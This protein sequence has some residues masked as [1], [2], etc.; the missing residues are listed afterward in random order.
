MYA[1]TM[2][3]D[4]LPAVLCVSLTSGTRILIRGL[5]EPM[6]S[7]SERAGS[8]LARWPLHSWSRADLLALAG[9]VTAI[10]IAVTPPLRRALI[11]GWRAVL[12]RAG[13]PHRKY[14]RWF[15]RQWGQYENPY[16]DD[17][18]NLDLS[19]TYVPLSFR[20]GRVGYEVLG[21]ATAV[22]AHRTMGN[23]V[24]EGAPGS[25]K[26]TL[27]KAYGVGVLQARR[28]VWQWGRR[29]VPF[30]IQ[31]RK[32]ARNLTGQN[33]VA[34]YIV[35]EILV[36]TIGMS[37]TQA[38][39]FF[40]YVL[41]R[42][43]VLVMLDG[44][45]EVTTDRYPV[46]LEAVRRFNNDH[47]PSRPTF[48]ARIIV[49]CRRQNFLRLRDEWV[50]VI[51]SRVC[52][53]A[54]LRNSDIFNYLNKLRPKFR[55]TNGPESFIQAVRVSG[56]L[57]LHRV[58]LILA[59][60]VGLYA[61]KDYF[62]IPSSIARLYKL[63][64]EEMLDR[65][66]FKRDPGG[67]ALVFQVGDKYRLLR[68]FALYAASGTDGFN[69]FSKT[70]LLDFSRSLAPNLDAVRDPDALVNEV[71]LRSG[72]LS[73]ITDTGH[74]VFAHRSIQEYLVAEELQSMSDSDDLLLG[75]ANDPEWRQVIQF[76]ASGRE[77]RSVSNFL[78]R[79][80]QLNSELAA[81]CLASARVSTDTA[82][83]VLESL[84]PIDGVRLAALAAATLSP[85]IAVQTMAIDSLRQ[86]VSNSALSSLAINGD[87]DS[88]L[89]LLNSLAGTNAAEIAALVPKVIE[90]IPDNPRLV[91]PLWRCLAAPGIER[92][93]ACLG[94]VRRLLDLMVDPEALDELARQE[95]Y[96]H[97][98]LTADI[99]RR[100]Y[101]FKEG[102][103]PSHNLITLLAWAEYLD[104]APRRS[105]RYFAAKEAGRLLRVEDDRRRTII[106]TP[107]RTARIISSA[108]ISAAFAGSVAAVS[109]FSGQITRPFGPWTVFIVAAAA[110][111][112]LILWTMLLYQLLK[113]L[114]NRPAR[115]ILDIEL[116]SKRS[117][118]IA[119]A[120]AD[121]VPE[122]LGGILLFAIFPLS[123][124]VAPLPL[125]A[126]SPGIFFATAAA[127][128]LL[129]LIS[130]MQAF[131]HGQHL[132]L[133]RPNPYIDI[134]DDIRCRHWVQM[135][136]PG[137]PSPGEAA[138]F[139]LHE[140]ARDD[141]DPFE[142]AL[143]G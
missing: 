31:L 122:L 132:Y 118:S 105:N 84:L 129:Y 113:G 109:V 59:M 96:T 54:P 48:Q 139:A 58:P 131:D 49:T 61:R 77:Q 47:D 91:E 67:G 79:L 90:R 73:D 114:K 62:E 50:P 103:D 11:R 38:N 138:M 133:Y 9:I 123:F 130:F 124:G 126:H 82:T 13:F 95:P 34:D 83:V 81:Y 14:A 100:A 20:S 125:L 66:R 36:S 35:D 128:E 142:T 111:G 44:L 32:L 104:V 12:M 69:E 15:I 10:V 41:E 21:I 1:L 57:D 39:Q 37:T 85:R 53:L 18:E 137:D 64:I 26:S 24:I 17:T 98:F 102:L 141:P 65:H 89:P 99:R 143:A 4:N 115:R 56:T 25:G 101:P 51:A 110:Y 80:S 40:R 46:V 29:T 72:L 55:L 33:G 116:T 8:I 22:L 68:E 92:Q 76:Y 127:G 108:V 19:N 71:V 16:L 117:G 5:G 94:I 136:P 6:M 78:E 74:Y 30:L 70:D 28:N 42:S 63:M 93:T 7:V 52:S 75:K 135:V 106:I 23:L 87:I 45:D 86:A 134:Y 140:S 107:F 3:Q 27:L 60:S 120:I 88:M 2:R 112:S 43:E 119:A 97:D 121:S